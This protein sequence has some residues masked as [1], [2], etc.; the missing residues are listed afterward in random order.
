MISFIKRKELKQ[1]PDWNALG[2]GKYFSDYMFTMDYSCEKGWHNATI[3]PYSDLSLSPATMVF[4]Y[5]QSVFEGMKAYKNTNED[6]LL[7]RP[8]EN[9]KRLNLSCERLCMPPL[10]HDIVLKGLTK[11]LKIESSWIPGIDGT[12]LYIRPFVISTQEGLGVSASESYKFIIILS[13]VGSYYDN[14]FKPVKIFVEPFYARAVI[15]GLGE[16][17]ASANYAASIKAQHNAKK[18]GYSQVL[19]LDAIYKKY[20]EEVGTMNIF[21]KIGNKIVTPNLTRSI[22][23]GVTRKSVI[24]LCKSLGFVVQERRISIDELVECGKD[25][26]LEE[27]FGSGTAAVISPISEFMWKDDII[28][29]KDSSNSPLSNKLYQILTNIQTGKLEDTFKWIYTIK[30]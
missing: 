8:Q 15:G 2:F 26:T 4:H 6:I 28:P 12:A 22:L 7:F 3:L 21:F 30:Q 9:I 20:I 18:L 29:V 1:K 17:K 27:A 14:N 10:P 16:A 24:D 19:W 25:G 13:P 11:L 23:N 5:G